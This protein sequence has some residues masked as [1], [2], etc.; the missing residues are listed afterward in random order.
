MKVNSPGE[1][2]RATPRLR[3]FLQGAVES[4]IRQRR[5]DVGHRVIQRK[6]TTPPARRMGTRTNSQTKKQGSLLG[7]PQVLQFLTF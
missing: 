2:A 3:A 6:S 7:S 4:H 1:A 5:A